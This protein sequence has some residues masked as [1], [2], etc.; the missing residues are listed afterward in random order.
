[1]RPLVGS[2]ECNLAQPSSCRPILCLLPFQGMQQLLIFHCS[3]EQTADSIWWWSKAAK[4]TSTWFLEAAWKIPQWMVTKIYRKY[5]Q[6]LRSTWTLQSVQSYIRILWVWMVSRGKSWFQQKQ[7]SQF[8]SSCW[9]K[10]CRWEDPDRRFSQIFSIRFSLVWGILEFLISFL[11]VEWGV[12]ERRFWSDDDQLQVMK[13][14]RPLHGGHWNI[15]N[16]IQ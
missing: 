8:Q 10:S 16:V 1:M 2:M 9:G 14:L 15:R 4:H 6:W 12:E 5:R 13:L 3:Y 11:A 7:L